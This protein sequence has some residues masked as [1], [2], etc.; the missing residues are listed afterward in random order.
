[1]ADL[2]RAQELAEPQLAAARLKEAEAAGIVAGTGAKRQTAEEK[3]IDAQIKHAEDELKFRKDDLALRTQDAIDSRRDAAENK[4]FRGR[5]ELANAEENKARLAVELQ[6]L[7]VEKMRLAVESGASALEIR[8][9]TAA[10]RIAEARA[11]S[12]AL[13]FTPEGRATALKA[14]DDTYKQQMEDWRARQV[15]GARYTGIP[16]APAPP[17]APGLAAGEVPE[18]TPKS[19]TVKPP[20]VTEKPSAAAAPATA[21][22]PRAINPQ[23]GAIVEWN[24]KEWVPVAR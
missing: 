23:T 9:M 15:P 20:I 13:A 21:A 24:G 6:R 22:R 8:A 11:T 7:G 3:Q 1:L 19:V 5:M 10:G 16:G 4:A 2:R 18:P 12:A 14:Y 17:A